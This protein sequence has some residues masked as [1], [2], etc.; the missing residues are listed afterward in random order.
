MSTCNEYPYTLKAFR[1][2]RTI[3]TLDLLGASATMSSVFTGGLKQR[4]MDIEKNVDAVLA[5]A[6]KCLSGSLPD[7]TDMKKSIQ[8]VYA[9]L[10]N[11]VTL[12]SLM[13]QTK[14]GWPAGLES[15]ATTMFSTGLYINFH[16]IPDADKSAVANFFSSAGDAF[17][18]T[19]GSLTFKDYF[20]RPRNTY[21]AAELA[22]LARGRRLGV[23]LCHEA[24][25]STMTEKERRCWN[26]TSCV[27][28]TELKYCNG[29]SGSSDSC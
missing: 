20:G 27:A 3:V 11:Q 15:A 9:L 26:G 8:D 21:T 23:L 7:A 1:S 2:N 18:S 12:Q 24:Q 6:A 17:L 14:S 25:A 16:M 22:L 4:L 5:S 19:F 29:N 28:T 13:E 10:N